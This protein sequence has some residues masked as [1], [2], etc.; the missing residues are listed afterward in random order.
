MVIA[1][2]AALI[3]PWFV[4]WNDYRASFEAEASRILGHR[5]HV[6]GDAHATILPSP[7]LTF[8][9]VE[10][11]DENGKRIMDVARFDVVIELMPLLQGEIRVV[12][13][14]LEKPMVN[15]SVDAAGKV[16][17]LSRVK[18]REPFDPDKVVLDN[19]TIKDGAL[20]YADAQTGVALPFDGI[21]ADLGACVVGAVACRRLLSRQW[22]PGGVPPVDRP[23]A[24]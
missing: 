10:V 1:L 17:W 7:S 16:A 13:M 4:N 14:T 24:R 12:S 9:K 18:L 21:S 20:D 11:D 23:R 3:V 15:V 6:E 5:V 2:F 19:I 22:R 8:T